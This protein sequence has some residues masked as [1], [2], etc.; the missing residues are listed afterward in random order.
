VGDNYSLKNPITVIKPENILPLLAIA[1]LI[2]ASLTLIQLYTNGYKEDPF[3]ND[4]LKLD[5]DGA[6]QC[7]D[8]SLIVCDKNNNLLDYCQRIWVPY[9]EPLKLHLLQ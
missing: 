4:I 7:R 5:R 1:T 2:P 3:P 6:K 9:Y 8:I